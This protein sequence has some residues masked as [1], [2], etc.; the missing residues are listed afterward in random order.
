MSKL[1][2]QEKIKIGNLE[3]PRFMSAPIDGVTDSPFRRLIRK[4]SKSELLF[5]EMRHVGLVANEKKKQSLRFD[6]VEQPL[7]FQ[8][9]ASSTDFIDKA[10]ENIIAE[11]FPMIN[12]NCGCPSRTVVGSGSGSA[13]M[14]DLDLFEKIVKHLSSRIKNRV[15]LTIKIRA[16]FKEKNG[17]QASQSA[18][19]HGVDAIVIHPRLQTGKFDA[20]LDFEMAKKIKSELKVPMV[21]SGEI[22]NFQ[23][24]QKT[25]DLTGADGFMIGRALIGTPWK[26]REICEQVVGN[27]FRVSAHESVKLAIENLDL[28]VEHY[29][30]KGF[31]M[32]KK[33]LAN[34]I[35]GV[36][37]AAAHRRNLMVSR[38]SEEMRDELK[39][40]AL[41]S[42]QSGL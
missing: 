41:E 33:Q 29:G 14:A 1:F 22:W 17:F 31:S 12:L 39:K 8:I 20:E 28:N 11:G 36:G 13:L 21:F 32:L 27:D 35:K 5:T 26:I 34:Y 10:V 24:A 40:I 3:I 9:S 38:S 42:E 18:C 15:A 4:F 2:W 25:Y 7:A 37:N 6:L 30:E 19:D 23:D 16:G